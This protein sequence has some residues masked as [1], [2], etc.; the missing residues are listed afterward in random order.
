MIMKILVTGADGYLIRNLKTCF[1]EHEICFVVRKN[2]THESISPSRVEA[3]IRDFDSLKKVF[4][5]FIPD[6]ILHAAAK[7]SIE[8]CDVEDS[9]MYETNVEG[10]K[11]IMKLAPSG[12]TVIYISSM[13][14]YSKNNQVPV[15][16]DAL[17]IPPHFYGFTKLLGEQIVRYYGNCRNVNHLILRL[18][19]LYGGDRKDGYIYNTIIKALKNKDI[20]IKTDGLVYW[21]TIS[22]DEV[23]KVLGLFLKVI[24]SNQINDIF[25][26]CHNEDTD[27]ID[28][29]QYIVNVLGST[30]RVFVE[31]PIGYDKFPLSNRKMICI[32][33][34]NPVIP[35]YESLKNYVETK[36]GS[37][38]E[39]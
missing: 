27:F 39:S 3:D 14:V 21:Q 18:P 32:L 37:A 22:V 19:G 25:N 31:Q 29:A 2:E 26:V 38:C 17:C 35:Y 7:I 10:T 30:S 23:D 33:G 1:I 13:T 28:T 16:E 6:V 20:I 36:K 8:E 9:E 12:S 24:Q 4:N 5:D 34:Q 15:M 11:N